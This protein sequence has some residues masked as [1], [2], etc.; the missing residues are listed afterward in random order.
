M[1][2]FFDS[3]TSTLNGVSW[4]IAWGWILCDEGMAELGRGIVRTAE[5]MAEV[6]Y[7]AV[8]KSGEFV[9]AYAYKLHFD[10]HPLLDTLS[11]RYTFNFFAKT[12]YNWQSVSCLDSAGREVIRFLDM[13]ALQR[14]GLRVCGAVAGIDK[15]EGGF[16]FSLV[17]ST[18]TPLTEQEQAYLMRDVEIMPAYLVKISELFGIPLDF[19]G[20]K[21]I[22]VSQL[23]REKA[24]AAFD[25]VV[26]GKRM[27][28]PETLQKIAVEANAAKDEDTLLLRRAC[29]RGGL[30]FLDARKAGANLES[31]D[32]YD[33]TS[34]YH[35]FIQSYRV[36]VGF[37]KANKTE[38][39]IAFKLTLNQSKVDVLRRTRPFRFFFNAE[40]EFK[41]LRLKPEYMKRGMGSLSKSKMALRVLNFEGMQSTAKVQRHDKKRRRDLVWG[42]AFLFEKLIKADKARINLTEQE[43]YIMSIFYD[44]DSL[45]PICGEIT[46]E[47]NKPPDWQAM[48]SA[49]LYEQKKLYKKAL[50]DGDAAALEKTG[51][52]PDLLTPEASREV[53]RN[54]KTEVNTLFGELV[55]ERRAPEWKELGRDADAPEI[56]LRPVPPYDGRE[57]GFF[58]QGMRV[59]GGAR[60][61]LA[62]LI[63]YCIREKIEVIYGDT[64][65]IAVQDKDGKFAALVDAINRMRDKQNRETAYRIEASTGEQFNLDGVG[66][67]NLSRHCAQFCVS[68][69]KTWGS[70]SEDGKVV[71]R[72]AGVGLERLAAFMTEHPDIYTLSDVLGWNT[73]YST[74]F[75]TRTLRTYPELYEQVEISGRDHQGQRFTDYAP[76]AIT[77]T[78]ANMK[79]GDIDSHRIDLALLEQLGNK[80][81]TRKRIITTKGLKNARI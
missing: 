59:S 47:S 71:L 6:I 1:F 21:I 45:K 12:E 63:D 32:F 5:D 73:I 80:Q 34:C 53:Y 24:R 3:E 42:S 55:R 31:V 54:I 27:R 2:L 74:K 52:T 64:D 44:W 40:V 30:V 18:E 67:I 43:L 60:L 29:N 8:K 79:S 38:L 77:L 49:Y 48:R 58:T 14:G 46:K 69:P 23:A 66:T 68:R 17:R 16:D 13:K 56:Q 9:R 28:T 50:I 81:N 76:R 35:F 70:I 65:S 37:K 36:P 39:E 15:L 72:A 33:F 61:Q 78:D 19:F 26:M 75:G 20:D 11:H 62:L 7:S 4:P 25:G 51:I 22:T 57:Y 10:L 41:N